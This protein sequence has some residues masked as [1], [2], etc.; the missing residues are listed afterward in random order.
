MSKHLKHIPLIS[1]FLSASLIAG[2]TLSGGVLAHGGAKG[3][4]KERMSV[5]KNIGKE[6]KKA[7]AM[8]KGKEAF[9]SKRI[10]TYAKTISETSPGIPDLFP[11]HSLQ[12]PTEALP[13][14][15]EEWDQFSALSLKLTE[16]AGKLHDVA[17]NGD[18]RAITMQFAKVGKVCSGCHTDYRKKQEK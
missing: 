15:W 13:A 10:S 9:D 11:Q 5:M 12:K 4:I 8:I 1:T 2:I 16:E 14:I 6:M 3:V 17:Q 7:G 18:R